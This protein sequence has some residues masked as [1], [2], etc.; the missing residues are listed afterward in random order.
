MSARS[1]GRFTGPG[2]GTVLLLPRRGAA[3]GHRHNV[4]TN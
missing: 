3:H 1:T 2:G 4:D